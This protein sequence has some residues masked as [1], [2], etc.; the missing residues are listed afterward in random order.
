MK[1][2]EIRDIETNE[3]KGYYLD[4]IFVPLETG[5]R[6]YQEIKKWL[7]EGNTP[8]PAFTEKERLEYFKNK[9]LKILKTEFEKRKTKSVIHSKTIDKDIDAGIVA[10]TNINGL[11]DILENDTDTVEFRLAD[12]S[13]TTVTKTQLVEMKKEII[14][15]GQQLYKNKWS[16]ET[17]I[18]NETDIEKL[19]NSVI[20]LDNGQLIYKE[21]KGE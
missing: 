10:L 12:N 20:D 13:F 6:H 8:E 4:G 16:I 9:L 17:Q 3:L 11:L 5:N 2:K 21:D 18:N 14:Q 1:V 19:K 15:A 7:E